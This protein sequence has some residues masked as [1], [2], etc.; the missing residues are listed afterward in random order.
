MDTHRRL[1]AALQSGHS[2]VAGHVISSDQL[3]R[4]GAHAQSVVSTDDGNT[5]TD[6][7]FE[8]ALVTAGVSGANAQ[9]PLS[10]AAPDNTAV[11]ALPASFDV[12]AY[13]LGA[14]APKP[15]AVAN[16]PTPALPASFDVNAYSSGA[17]A[18][19]PVMKDG[20]GLVSSPSAEFG[21]KLMME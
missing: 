3:S 4:A 17:N 16:S 5:F 9:P 15:V 13:S 7:L 11:T 18:P 12:N 6:R 21:H 2:L 19:K 1:Y 8:G 20:G 10:T 14:N